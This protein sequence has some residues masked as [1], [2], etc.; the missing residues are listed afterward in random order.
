MEKQHTALAKRKEIIFSLA[1]REGI[2]RQAALVELKIFLTQ[3]EIY[4][5]DIKSQNNE[6]AEKSR[7][8]TLDKF[9][10]DEFE[11][12]WDNVK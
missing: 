6:S 1:D 7:I 8:K 4:L 12:H 5:S 11:K 9:Q 2:N 3:A 10:T